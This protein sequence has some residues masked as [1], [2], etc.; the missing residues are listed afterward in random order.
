MTCK[1][2]GKGTRNNRYKGFCVPCYHVAYRQ[3]HVAERAETA[4]A[5]YLRNKERIRATKAKWRDAN[6]DKI[7]EEAKRQRAAAKIAYAYEVV[8][9]PIKGWGFR[10]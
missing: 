2:C 8:P 10:C 7:N 6:R 4:R 3:A 5:Y 1:V 9:V